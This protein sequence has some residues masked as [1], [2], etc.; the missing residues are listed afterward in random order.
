M[1]WNLT[2]PEWA[3][4][5]T[6]FTCVVYKIVYESCHYWT[7][8]KKNCRD[9]FFSIDFFLGVDF[10]WFHA[11]MSGDNSTFVWTFIMVLTSEVSPWELPVTPLHWGGLQTRSEWLIEENV[12][13]RDPTKGGEVSFLPVTSSS[14][15]TGKCLHRPVDCRKMNEL[16]DTGEALGRA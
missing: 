10:K 13:Q 6:W 8:E 16:I 11:W 4:C 1:S 9:L 12:D 5:T 3:I 2:Q 7:K 15:G 14:P